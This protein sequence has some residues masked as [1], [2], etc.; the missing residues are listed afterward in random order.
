MKNVFFC[1]LFV[2][3]SINAYPIQKQNL[4]KDTTF[5]QLLEEVLVIAKTNKEEGRDKPLSN[6]ESYLSDLPK[7]D[8]I[9]RGGYAWEP[10]LNNMNSD[11]LNISIDG[12]MIFGACTDKMDPVTSYVS[13]PNLNHIEINSGQ[14]NSELGTTIGGSMNLSLKKGDFND[15]GWD[16]NLLSGYD[17]NGNGQNYGFNTQ[18]QGERF[19]ALISIDHKS[20]DNYKAGGQ[21]E[22]LYSGF[23]KNNLYT[24]F[25]FKIN[26]Q[27]KIEALFI[28]DRATDVGY[29]A[30][31]MDV[32]LARGIIG[33]T[34]YTKENWTENI[35]RFRIKLYA[36]SVYHLMDD[37]NRPDVPIRMDMPGWTETYGANFKL[38]YQLDD[39]NLSSSFNTYYNHALAE[40]TM[41]PNDPNEVDMFM[42][43]WP[44]VGTIQSSVYTKDSY[45]LSP[46]TQL[47]ANLRLAYQSAYIKSDVGYN[48]LAILYPN[49]DRRKNYGLYSFSLGINHQKNQI[50]QQLSIGSGSRA[51][52]VSEAYGYFLFNS[53]ENFDYIGN[54]NLDS[55]KSFNLNYNINL[56]FANN[57]L[58]FEQSYFHTKDY[59][60]GQI[61]PDLTPMTIGAQGVKVYQNIDY[62]NIYNANIFL[63]TP[64]ATRLEITNKVIYAV[65]RDNQ[66]QNLPWIAPLTLES[67]VNLKMN[68]WGIS[69]NQSYNFE[70][71]NYGATYGGTP[72]EPYYLMD[73][74]GY[75]NFN[76]HGS[77][78]KLNF[79]IENLLDKSYSNYSSWNNLQE[80]G[81]NF[82]INLNLSI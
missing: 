33:S 4:Q 59:I 46:T 76:I 81:R 9:K 17:S 62:T 24:S 36:N 23:H 58:G 53:S 72:T 10:V 29:P 32:A 74:S 69:L 39:H 65:A 31:P 34:T 1:I 50:N 73:V 27:E 13:L 18:Y 49:F 67:D 5:T 45:A 28:Y 16:F 79:G 20:S 66:G 43:T 75:K 25:G 78:L 42:Y 80:P 19:Y 41:F 8:M 38:D 56:E 64:I 12:M 55:E 15:K 44:D 6:I 35:N 21:E 60:I 82:F 22:I 77:S 48:S 14:N 3:G 26:D 52:N 57:T 71:K 54:P 47:E 63:R 30:L 2:L 40:M 7:V 37:S 11:R 70:Q 61:D 51:P 68:S